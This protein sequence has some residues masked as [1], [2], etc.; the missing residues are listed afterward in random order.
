MH[1]NNFAEL[2]LPKCGALIVILATAKMMPWKLNTNLICLYKEKEKKSSYSEAV[3]LC[4]FYMM[5]MF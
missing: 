3:E 5:H 2:N 4:Y 1:I